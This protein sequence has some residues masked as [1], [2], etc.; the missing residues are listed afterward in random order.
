MGRQGAEQ[1]CRSG[2]SP[3]LTN[4]TGSSHGMMLSG[5]VAKITWWFPVLEDGRRKQE[6]PKKLVGQRVETLPH[7]GAKR[8]AL[9][10]SAALAAYGRTPRPQH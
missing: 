5:A 7:H 9:Q 3:L 1:P 6:A 4:S 8:K 2:V 10:S